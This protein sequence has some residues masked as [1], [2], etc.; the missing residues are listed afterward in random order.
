MG[1]AGE[2]ADWPTVF[3]HRRHHRQIMQMAACQPRIVGD[4]GIALAHLSHWKFVEEMFD[5]DGHGIDMARRTCD[6][7]G[8]HPPLDIENAGGKIAR[9]AHRGAERGAQQCLSLFLDDR[10]QS[11][12]HNLA[13]NALERAGFPAHDDSS[14]FFRSSKI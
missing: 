9:L 2:R 4:I 7:L 12:P 11:V 13:L 14:P 6:G 8:K 10:N 5:R 3:E 1:G